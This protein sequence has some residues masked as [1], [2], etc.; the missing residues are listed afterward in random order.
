M[1]RKMK[2]IINEEIQILREEKIYIEFLTEQVQIMEQQGMTQEQ[3]NEG[4]MDMLSGLLGSLGTSGGESITD[5]LKVM[6]AKYIGSL[7]GIREEYFDANKSWIACAITNVIEN[8][9]FTELTKYFG[10]NRCNEL[11]DLIMQAMQ[12]CLFE[13]GAIENIMTA[14]TGVPNPEEGSILGT[15]SKETASNMLKNTEFAQGLRTQLAD[16]ICKIEMKDILDFAGQGVG[17]L[18]GSFTKGSADDVA[19]AAATA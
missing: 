2:R 3:I 17:K 19:A 18:L 12:E 8:I 5:T 11:A 10:D 6:A 7:I 4:F 15:L 9:K 1:N 14:I 16:A 13:K